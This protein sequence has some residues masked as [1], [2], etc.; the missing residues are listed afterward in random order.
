MTFFETDVTSQSELSTRQR[1]GHYLA[2]ALGLLSVVFALNL[3]ANAQSATSVYINSE[4]GITARYPAN[5][6]L[7]EA[8][9]TYVFRVRD[10]SEVGFGTIFQLSILPIG[11]DI[12]EQTLVDLLAIE[13]A[14]TLAAY[15]TL[16]VEP[17]RLSDERTGILSTYTYVDTAL[18]PF[19]QT[20]PTVV[21]GTDVIVI[22]RDQAV[23]VTMIS[24]AVHYDLNRE[25]FERFVNQLEY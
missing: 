23:V 14:Q 20:L 7:D 13:R 12:A 10:V 25:R 2:V 24:D 8:S 11:P 4:A 15:R 17:Y 9:D 1:W 19:L 5:W 18:N 16:D 22:S 6:L 21:L 3:R